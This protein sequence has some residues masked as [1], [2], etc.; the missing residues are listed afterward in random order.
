[1]G[2]T[3]GEA[4]HG[5]RPAAARAIA[6]HERNVGAIGVGVGCQDTG[7]EENPEAA[8]LQE[9]WPNEGLQATANSLA[10]DS[11]P[12]TEGSIPRL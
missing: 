7:E 2:L 12:N 5:P 3:V 9:P 6:R 8:S 10:L 4:P 1:M 11:K